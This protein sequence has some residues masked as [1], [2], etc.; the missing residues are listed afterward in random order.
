MLYKK[1]KERTIF[2]GNIPAK[3][4]KTEVKRFFFKYGRIDKMWFRSLATEDNKL[5]K[6]L[7][8]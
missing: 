3:A 4:T 6:K 2:V 1:R 7:N 8:I 5:S